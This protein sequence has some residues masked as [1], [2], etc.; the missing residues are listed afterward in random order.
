MSANLRIALFIVTI[1]LAGCAKSSSTQLAS[2]DIDPY[3][4]YLPSKTFTASVMVSGSAV[5]EYRMNGNGVASDGGVVLTIDAFLTPATR[6]YSLTVNSRTYTVTSNLG[7][8]S[9]QQDVVTKLK[10]AINADTAAGLYAYGI[11]QLTVTQ[12]GVL[13]SPTITGLSRMTSTSTNP[14]ARPIRYAEIAAKSATGEIIQCAETADDGSFG[15]QLPANSG[16]YTIEVRAR[17]ANSRSNAYILNDPT[18]NLQHSVSATVGSTS[19]TNGVFVRAPVRGTLMGG[20]FNI[21][22]QILNAQEYLRT[23]TENCDQSAAPNFFAGCVPFVSAPLVKVYWTPGLSPAVYVNTTGSISYY[24]NNRRELFLQGGQN[25]NVTSSDM[26]HFDNSVI[27]HEYGHFIEDVYGKPDSPGGSHNADSIIDP[28]L[29]WGEGWAN[30]FQAAVTG[31]AVYRDTYGTPDCTSACAGTYFNESVDPVGTPPNDA[32]TTGAL[33]EGNFREFSVTRMLW[34]VIKPTGGA[35]RFAEIWRAIVVAGSGMK[36]VDDPFKTV[37]RLH[38]IQTSFAGTGTWS[39]LRLNEEQVPGFSV[40]ATEFTVG[41]SCS[42]SPVEMTQAR[43]PGDNG[44]FATSDQYRN[45]DFY[46]F[47]HAGGNFT[48]ELFYSKDSSNTADLDLYVY[49]PRYVFGRASDILMSSAFSGE[50]CPASGSLSDASNGFRA[51]NGCPPPP[52]GLS[53]TYGYEKSTTSLAAGTY[54]INVQADTTRGAGA[55]T[56]YVLK[57]NGQVICPQP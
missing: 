24:V 26:D 13:A 57:L 28:R 1:L 18:N 5:Y 31:D 22:D 14:I 6:S 39:A 49:R 42:T 52:A 15:F 17:A 9:A 47:N 55:P 10:A 16:D 30:F 29:A 54:M 46:R 36:N 40:Y 45:N 8:T 20:A 37:G 53:S 43:S 34:D 27:I 35:S 56:K 32:P 12:P 33:G 19:S 51:Q 2:R 50:G 21:L 3:C 7:Q 38:Q 4:P 44:S 23:Q 25:G 48:L 41:G 11:A